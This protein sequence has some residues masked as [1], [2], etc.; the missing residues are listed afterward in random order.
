MFVQRNKEFQEYY[1][2][3]EIKRLLKKRTFKDERF[4]RKVFYKQ[5]KSEKKYNLLRPFGSKR[6]I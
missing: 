6:Q 4:K 3:E 5:P 1:V 2:K